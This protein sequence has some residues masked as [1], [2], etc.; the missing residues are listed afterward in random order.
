MLTYADVYY[1]CH[2]TYQTEIYSFIGDVTAGMTHLGLH[3][4]FHLH[5]EDAITGLDTL[6]NYDRPDWRRIF[7]DLSKQHPQE[8][9]GVFFCGPLSLGKQVLGLLALLVQ[10]YGY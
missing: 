10:T 2:A 4:Y 7:G 5:K 3:S 8:R 9:V 1:T 6:T